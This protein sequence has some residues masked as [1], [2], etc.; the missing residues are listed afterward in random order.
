MSS[1]R[2]L[3]PGAAIGSHRVEMLIGAGGM[4]EVYR[5]YDLQLNRSV[6]IKVVPISA[7]GDPDA[8]HRLLREARAAASLNHANVCT[9]YEVGQIDEQAFI[10]MELV[11]GRSLD[12][13][14]PEGGLPVD[15]VV[16]YGRQLADAL[17][18]AH[19]RGIVHRDL[20]PANIKITADGVLKVLDF[21]LAKAAADSP[22]QAATD[23][24]KPGTVLGTAAYMSPEQAEG[25]PVDKR[26]DI[27]AF[28]VVMYQMLTGRV[29]FRGD[30]FAGTVAAVLSSEA[31]LTRVPP[32]LRPMLRACLEKDSRHRL[33]DIGDAWRLIEQP[34]SDAMPRTRRWPVAA[35]VGLALGAAITWTILRAPAPVS[36]PVMRWSTTLVESGGGERGVA[37]SR[38]GRV[39][40]Y[41]GRVLPI[42]PIWVRTL[43]QMEGRPIPGTEGGRRPF[44]SPDGKW[45]AYFSS[46]GRSSL[47]K[48][49]LAGGA[50]TRLCEAAFFFGGSWGDDDQI[51]FTGPDGLMRVSASGG[52]CEALTTSDRD[53]TGRPGHRSPQILRGGKAVLFGIASPRGS[54][55]SQIA[56]LDLASREQHLL[57]QRGSAARYLPSGHLIYT[58]STTIFAI[59]FDAELLKAT[60]P[61]VLAVDGVQWNPLGGIAD[62]A[63]SDSGTLV[64]TSAVTSHRTLAWIER[65]DGTMVPSPAPPREYGS[66]SVSPDGRRA[67]TFLTRGGPGILIV[68]LERGTINQISDRGFFPIWTPDGTRI[69]YST[70]GEL[71]WAPADGSGNPEL[72]ATEPFPIVE[73]TSPDG[74]TLS[75]MVRPS[76]D[77]KARG[78]IKLLQLPGAPSAGASV[79]LSPTNNHSETSA[80]ISPDGKWIAYVSDESGKKQV[81]LRSYP[82]PGGKVAVSIDG[83]D[84]PRWSRNPQELF[85]RYATTNQL[86]TA[87]IAMTTSTGPG[88]PR[89][90][91]ALTTSLWDVSPDGKR[92][93]VVKDPGPDADLGTVQV[94]VNWFE[95]LRKKTE[96]R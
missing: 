86:M 13:L 76:A 32:A 50:P 80:R 33:R 82:G 91:F 95:E 20:K 72:L 42:R 37:L 94:V 73:S 90:L 34:T 89:A 16:Q 44:L 60:G 75:Y 10:V 15:Q 93:L 41:T 36:A 54:D 35:A 47:M 64:Y 1:P 85:F 81:H 21:G 30:S 26:T 77:A 19:D 58:R 22:D 5:A 53:E 8:Q 79:L 83:G 66:V 14:I 18:H 68:D 9:I 63:V 38:D 92:F 78:V 45:L 3:T 51:V 39:L 12:T 46:F 24:T 17:A 59:P 11:G 49:S 6:A 43:D 23:L 62:Y 84:E 4:G 2:I 48:V 87:D 96:S 40:A 61:E 56:V 69:V 52:P 71:F 27:W 28:G 31:D 7:I 29:P 74:R 57:E 25:K 55:D 67:A 65:S 88:R 70:T